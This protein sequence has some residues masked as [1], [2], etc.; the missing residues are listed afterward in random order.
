MNDVERSRVPD[1]RAEPPVE[2]RE[3][4]KPEIFVPPA[5]G[6]T[7]GGRYFFIGVAV[8]LVGALAFG[9]WRHYSLHAQV[10]STAEQRR[11]FVPSVRVAP[12]RASA[13]TVSIQ[14]AAHAR[15]LAWSA[16]A[17]GCSD[18]PSPLATTS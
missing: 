5:A 12:V 2:A 10:T 1:S 16:S 9:F 6:T 8:L 3:A 11:D 15:S 13:S 4:R 7:H 17:N 18:I 14:S